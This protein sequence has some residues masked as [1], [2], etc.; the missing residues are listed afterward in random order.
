MRMHPA[1]RAALLLS[2]SALAALGQ[3]RIVSTAPAITETLFALGLGPKV[4]GVSTYCRYP[5]EALGKAKVGTYLQPNT[6]AILRLR[7]DLVIMERLPLQAIA[8]LESAGVRVKQISTG[9][10][11]TNLQMLLDIAAAANVPER[12]AALKAKVLGEIEAVRRESSLRSRKSVMFIL[13]RTPGRLEGIVAVGKASYLNDLI[14]AAGGRNVLAETAMSY[15]KVALEG[16]IRLK[17]DVIIDMGDMAETARVTE[18]HRR[19]VEALWRANSDVQSRVHAVAN[20]I[21]VVPGPRMGEAAR[22]FFRLIH[23]GG[24]AGGGTAR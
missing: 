24:L 23:G 22:E 4:I 6:E 12:G 8:Q 21:F 7:P 14:V 9:D 3:Q 2:V 11:A 1:I 16:V 17:P 10:L 15:P 19:S 13:G 18:E 5:A 20:D